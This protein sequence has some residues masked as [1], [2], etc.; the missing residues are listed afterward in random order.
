M[1]Q[2]INMTALDSQV[3]G[4]TVI[5]DIGITDAIVDF[6]KLKSDLTEIGVTISQI[7]DRLNSDI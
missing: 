3:I 1:H 6:D 2:E 5:F 4:N 7:N